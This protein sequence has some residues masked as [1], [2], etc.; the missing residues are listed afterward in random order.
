MITTIDN[1][2]LIGTAHVSK[3]SASLVKKTVLELQPE[4]VA[5]ELDKQRLHSLLEKQKN[6]NKKQNSKF[7][8][9]SLIKRV[10]FFGFLF[11][12]VSGYLQQKMGKTLN[13]DPG[14]DMLA[15]VEIAK[16]Q[17][18]PL[19]LADR[20]I[21]QT[22]SQFK[23]L[24]FLQK[25]S[26]IKRMVFSKMSFDERKDLA[27]KLQKGQLDNQVITQVIEQ[28]KDEIPELYDILIH[29]RNVYMANEIIK[30]RKKGIN[31]MVL[32]I[33]AGHL[34]GI[35]EILKEKLPKLE[36]GKIFDIKQNKNTTQMSFKL[37]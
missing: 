5:I 19:C 14:I 7:F 25:M 27:G 22:I 32:V 8:D 34:P 11:L 10:G 12:K 13:I 26:M 29:Q 16:E 20:P 17:N 30:L 35:E 9:R 31:K 28:I 1:V 4:I 37:E 3:K 21:L 23:K 15:G 6:P 2:T 36:E 18:I 33:G 24:S